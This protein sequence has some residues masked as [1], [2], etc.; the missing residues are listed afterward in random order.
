MN[1]IASWR[2]FRGDMTQEQLAERLDTSRNSINRIENGEQPYSQD[3]LEAI[4][5]ELQCA[6]S[7]L[8][9]PPGDLKFIQ[10]MIKK[11]G[12]CGTFVI[13][14]EE[15]IL[16]LWNTAT[17]LQIQAGTPAPMARLAAQRSLIAVGALPEPIIDD[18]A[19][20]LDPSDLSAA[21]AGPSRQKYSK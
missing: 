19:L 4:A 17:H 7:D 12:D 2:R 21:A 11:A 8:L 3:S 16:D 18:P 10:D 6:P 5:F 14:S 15:Q 9:R 1:F 20:S 13:L